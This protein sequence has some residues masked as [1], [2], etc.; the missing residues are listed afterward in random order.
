M[1]GSAEPPR[2]RRHRSEG[3]GRP[4]HR[5]RRPSLCAPPLGK[6]HACARHSPAAFGKLVTELDAV[7]VRT[8]ANSA[9]E[10]T[11]DAMSL[12]GFDQQVD[13][14]GIAGENAAAI[15]WTGAAPRRSGD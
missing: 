9:A 1:T 2:I 6:A 4:R 5:P 8:G 12:R 7:A 15:Q 11:L 3:H 10:G 13:A 14:D